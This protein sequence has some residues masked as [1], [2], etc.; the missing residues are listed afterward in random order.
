MNGLDPKLISELGIAAFVMVGMFSLIGWVLKCSFDIKKEI[1]R[2]AEDERKI[3]LQIISAFQVSLS[4]NNQHIKESLKQS[5]EYIQTAHSEHIKMIETSNQALQNSVEF[6]K[7]CAEMHA[8]QIA[9]LDEHYKVL[10][11]INGE[12]H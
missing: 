3:F 6:R 9:N 12:K 5:G 2:N 1:L 11:R 10:L 7:E 4:E 8:R